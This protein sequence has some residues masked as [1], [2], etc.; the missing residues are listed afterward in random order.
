MANIS[1]DERNLNKAQ[2]L[3]DEGVNHYLAIAEKLNAEALDMFDILEG[4]RKGRPETKYQITP[5][6]E[7]ALNSQF[8]LWMSTVE[9]PEKALSHLHGA[10]KEKYTKAPKQPKQT[11]QPTSPKIALFSPNAAG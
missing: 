9:N 11:D 3:Y 5:R 7:K 6:Q 4:I 1:K 2:S 10:L 8:K